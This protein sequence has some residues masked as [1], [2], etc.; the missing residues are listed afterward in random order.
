M[1]PPNPTQ[2]RLT[3]TSGQVHFFPPSRHSKLRP[4]SGLP[5]SVNTR[6]ARFSGWPGL[7]R[8][9]QAWLTRHAQD[10]AADVPPPP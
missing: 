3:P 4:T 8:A 2:P 1:T 6:P 7:T 9:V 5:A 10:D